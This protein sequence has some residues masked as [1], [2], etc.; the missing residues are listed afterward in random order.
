MGSELVPYTGPSDV[1]LV[2]D[3]LTLF[4]LD[5]TG[6]TEDTWRE[7]AARIHLAEETLDKY[8][9]A[10][11]GWAIG[12]WAVYGQDNFSEEYKRIA[13]DLKFAT[14]RECAAV[15]RTFPDKE[16]RGRYNHERYLHFDYFKAVHRLGKERAEHFLEEA[17]QRGLSVDELKKAVKLGT[18]GA[19]DAPSLPSDP[20]SKP[21]AEDGIP[22]YQLGPHRLICADARDLDWVKFLF[23]L[24]RD[25]L[26]QYEQAAVVWTD[27][28]YGVAYVGKTADA[29]TIQA[30][31]HKGSAL[32]DLLTDSWTVASQ[33]MV[34]AA[35]FYVAGPSGENSLEFMQSFRSARAPDQE[36][37][38]HGALRPW[39][40]RQNL[41]WLKDRMIMGHQDYHYK[42]ETIFY[43][44]GPGGA[45]GRHQFDATVT[46]VKRD[47]T[48]V[49]ERFYGG[50]N[51]TSIFEV[52]APS[53]SREHPTMKP[54]ELIRQALENSSQEG[55]IVY[56]P[57]A[58]SGSTMIAADVL[59]R[60][61]F[62]VEVDPAYCDVIRNRW[63]A[64]DA[65]RA[66]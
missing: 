62:M 47:G 28:P 65:S 9:S 26:V 7:D 55:D 30:D 29:L 37:G 19:D 66:R 49:V 58:G 38:T 12:D 61:A 24:D 56:D 45:A 52:P 21:Y 25:S 18:A 57:F 31:D 64:Y 39:R 54:V 2:S 20:V 59:G 27:P 10:I 42:H 60:R 3:R 35:P 40:L 51:A 1:A 22:I 43:G 33:V 63:A 48:A 8:R 23:S 14:L 44:Y 17:V 13:K 15:A 11:S 32:L 6:A 50:D 36:D 4:G 16:F 34:D 5:Y 46:G 53:A 41:V